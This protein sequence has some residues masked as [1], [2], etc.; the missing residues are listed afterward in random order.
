MQGTSAY[1]DCYGIQNRGKRG[2][3]LL[4]I[5]IVEDETASRMLLQEYTQRYFREAGEKVNIQVFSDG[6]DIAEDYKPVWDILLLDI[7]MPHLDGMSAAGKIRCVDPFVV[8]IFVTNMARYAIKGYEVGALDFVLKPVNYAQI[9]MKL[10]RAVKLAQ[11][12]EGRYVMV[13]VDGVKQKLAAEHILY[14]EVIGHRLHI[15]T[16]EREYV[17]TGSMQNM[18]EMLAG[19]PFAR[20]SHSYLVN[21]RNVSGIQKDNVLVDGH[22]LPLSRSKRQEFLQRLSDYMGGMPC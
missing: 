22:A 7:E 13:S 12:R 5:A 4:R 21:L 18:E 15:Y 3:T 20:C 10:R 9:S 6:L 14:I 2:K 19:L 8:I 11:L 17:A 16:Q 1:G